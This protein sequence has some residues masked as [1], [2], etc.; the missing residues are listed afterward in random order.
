M[1]VPEA[2][3][4]IFQVTIKYGGGNITI[5]TLICLYEFGYSFSLQGFV[6]DVLRYYNPSS[7]QIHPNECT[8]LSSFEKLLRILNKEPII[9]V[10]RHCY[11]LISST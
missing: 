7:A 5:I 4:C 11:T 1:V 9:K 2:N 10:F 3:N 6:R 8:I